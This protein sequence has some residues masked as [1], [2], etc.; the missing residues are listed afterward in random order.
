MTNESL[1]NPINVVIYSYKGKLLKRVVDNLLQKSSKKNMIY[2]HVY[3][4][5]T[6]TKQE[7]FDQFDSLT[8]NHIF[9]D[10][11]KSPCYYKQNI[12]N[13]SKFS[14]TLLLSDNIFLN[15]DWDEFLLSSLPNKQS[16][17]TGKNNTILSNDGIFYLKKEEIKT[18]KMQQVYFANR[19]LIF[20]HTS[21]LQSVNYP[22][23]IKY[24]GEEEIL[25]LLYF[26]NNIKMYSC[27]DKFY[28]KE[29]SDTIKDLYTT[30]S[31]YHNY[32]EMI[33]LLKNQKNKYD[34]IDEPLMPDVNMFL[35]L[36]QIDLESIHP[37][38][39]PM[40]DVE[41]DQDLSKF[42][43]IDSKKFMTKI[44]YID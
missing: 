36:H 9:W 13:N 6:L 1:P 31:K 25:S 16:I 43:D 35:K 8:Y 4:Q 37:L 29:S 3:D 44:N 26:S 38:P 41:Y 24:Y 19:D 21:T 20:A 23:Y 33:D 5:S 32:N 40:N 14:Y 10:K 12:I 7:Y 34:S 18:E 28:T 22:S 27:P 17:I 39:F 30:F 11:I 2:V 42:D 15:Q